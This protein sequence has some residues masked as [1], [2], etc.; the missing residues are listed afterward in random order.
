MNSLILHR[1]R[2]I[3]LRGHDNWYTFRYSRL[4]NKPFEEF[5]LKGMACM[6]NLLTM[7][8]T[9]CQLLS[10]LMKLDRSGWVKSF[11]DKSYNIALN[12]TS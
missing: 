10:R 6:H 5:M 3:F 9:D 1:A 4:S 8:H 2:V 11:S 12:I 7:N